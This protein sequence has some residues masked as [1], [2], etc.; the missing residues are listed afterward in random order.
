M[1]LLIGR[2]CPIF[3]QLLGAELQGT[4][5]PIPSDPT[6]AGCIAG[7][8]IWPPT[9][10]TSRVR[11]G[12]VPR[13]DP[14]RGGTTCPRLVHGV[15]PPGTPDTMTAS[16]Q[17]PPPDEEES[18]PLI[19]FT[20]YPLADRGGPDKGGQFATRPAGGRRPSATPGDTSR[21][22]R[23]SRGTRTKEPKTPGI[24][25]PPPPQQDQT[26]RG[27]PFS[28]TRKNLSLPLCYPLPHEW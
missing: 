16:E 9:R 14:E 4:P 22:M 12:R 13:Q 18:P 3:A 27:V 8:P 10:R 7:P 24:E 23:A 19:D 15:P 11:L 6:P 17:A 21:S 2:D 28:L 1:P 20:D 26:R 5:D 25:T